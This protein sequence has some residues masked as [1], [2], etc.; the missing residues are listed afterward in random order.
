[1][2]VDGVAGTSDKD[3]RRFLHLFCSKRWIPEPA[4]VC[5]SMLGSELCEIT[6]RM[7]RCW[8]CSVRPRPGARPVGAIVVRLRSLPP[9][10]HSPE[11]AT[12]RL[13]LRFLRGLLL[14]KLRGPVELLELFV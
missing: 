6:V 2:G 7:L 4:L 9:R 10:L 1:M 12:N 13:L 14:C 5:S 3:G 8:A 11:Q